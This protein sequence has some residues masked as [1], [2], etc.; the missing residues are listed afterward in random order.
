MKKL[1]EVEL[2]NKLVLDAG[3]GACGMTKFLEKRGADIISIDINREYMEECRSKLN[4]GDF[5]QADLSDLRFIEPASFDHVM[6]KGTISALS[7]NKTLFVT[8]VF[9]EFYRVLKDQGTLTVIDY[10]PFKEETSPSPLD[11]IQVG[12][13]RLEKAVYE[14]FGESHLEEYP[15]EMIKKELRSI[16][17]GEVEESIRRDELPWSDELL[18]EHEE[19]IQEKI[20][21]VEEDHL[22]DALIKKLRELMGRSKEKK[23]VSGAMFE[24]RAKK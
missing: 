20:E 5:I 24:L 6:C 4:K 11:D 22:R 13:W 2:Q 19:L 14:L 21:E 17:F 10:Y 3:T 7:E 23:V 16:G 15:P 18:G 12:I 1:E 9:R 8:S